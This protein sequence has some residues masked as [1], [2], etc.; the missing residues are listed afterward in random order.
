MKPALL[1]AF[2]VL[3]AVVLSVILMRE[4]KRQ[5]NAVSALSEPVEVT[6]A[7]VQIML[8]QRVD[9]VAVT[10]TGSMQPHIPAGKGIVAYVEVERVSFAQLRENDLVVFRAGP[11]NILHQLAAKEGAAWIATGLHNSGYDATRVT[12]DNFMGRV[13]KTYI[14]K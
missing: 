6:S 8:T 9:L 1:A 7:E 10:G 4:L 14:I 2:A 3:L 5:H 12:A 13:V 11:I